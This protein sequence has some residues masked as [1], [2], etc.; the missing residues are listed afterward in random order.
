M[1]PHELIALKQLI[2]NGKSSQASLKE[3]LLEYSAIELSEKS[4]QS[5]CGML[6]KEFIGKKGSEGTYS[7]VEF[8]SLRMNNDD[9]ELE[10]SVSP[11]DMLSNPNFYCAINDII[12]FGLARYQ[13][14]FAKADHGLVLYEKYTRRDICRMLNWPQDNSST[15]YGYRVK[16]GTCPIFVT[17]NKDADI[18][19]STRYADCFESPYVFSW[20]TRSRLTLDSNEVKQITQAQTTDLSVYLFVKKSNNEGSDFYYLGRVRPTNPIQ[21][22]QLDD[23]GNKLDIVNF[24]LE[25]EHPVRDDIYEY[26]TGG[27]E[28]NEAAGRIA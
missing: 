3:A 10:V 12:N 9:K 27:E 17:H 13:E 1:R 16:H 18:S 6:D 15:I 25:L 8:A 21:M 19:E 5:T 11:E 20:M 7:S 24:K 28:P 23:K 4:Y 26:F 22:L 14:R 2:E